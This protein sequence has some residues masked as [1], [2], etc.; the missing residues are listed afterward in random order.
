MLLQLES[1]ML[2]QNAHLQAVLAELKKA[3]RALV[4]ADCRIVFKPLLHISIPRSAHQNA[5]QASTC[6]PVCYCLPFRIDANVF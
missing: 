5:G 3:Q 1:T 4:H 6:L 2:K